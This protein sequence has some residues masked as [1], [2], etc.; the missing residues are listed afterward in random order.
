MSVVLRR[1]GENFGESGRRDFVSIL[2]GDSCPNVRSV[3]GDTRIVKVVA[4][5]NGV[6]SE[7]FGAHGNISTV[8]CF[9]EAPALLQV[10]A[11]FSKARIRS[12]VR[13]CPLERLDTELV[14][15]VV[16]SRAFVILLNGLKHL[17]DFEDVV[18]H[19]LTLLQRSEGSEFL[20][21]KF[22]VVVIS[23]SHDSGGRV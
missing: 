6:R 4:K 9:H 10:D 7:P 19:C 16:P 13:I 1:V 18:V 11:A 23:L 3:H 22:R 21:S 20:D 5:C 2:V 12:T 8:V 14:E 17:F 15:V